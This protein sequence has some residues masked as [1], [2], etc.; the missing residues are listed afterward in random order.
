MAC[1][2]VSTAAAFGQDPTPVSCPQSTCNGAVLRTP[3]ASSF[4]LVKRCE[5]LL[6][7]SKQLSLTSQ[8]YASDFYS[9][10]RR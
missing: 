9:T 5:Q 1:V 10:H 7:W 2:C 6:L 3:S 8:V 4:G